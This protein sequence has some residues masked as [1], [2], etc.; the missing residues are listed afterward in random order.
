[1][2]PYYW[3]Y[4]VSIPAFPTRFAAVKLSRNFIKNVW[5]IYARSPFLEEKQKLK[6]FY[7]DSFLTQSQIEVATDRRTDRH[8]LP[9]IATYLWGRRCL[10]ANFR[11]KQLYSL[12]LCTY[13]AKLGCT[14]WHRM[15]NDNNAESERELYI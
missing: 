6:K 5:L 15:G 13:S 4:N 2:P 3:M 11:P 7:Q 12:Q 10:L 9:C 1:M 8:T 14:L